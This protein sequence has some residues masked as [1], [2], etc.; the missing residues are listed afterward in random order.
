MKIKRIIFLYLL[1]G[2]LNGVLYTADRIDTSTFSPGAQSIGLGSSL[3]GGVN[4]PSAIYWNSAALAMVTA[5][6]LFLTVNAPYAINYCAL[7]QFIPNYGTFGVAFAAIPDGNITVQHTS[8]AWAKSFA[9]ALGLG[10]NFDFQQND[11]ALGI[12]GGIGLYYR[13]SAQPSNLQKI[14][15]F[16]DL[17]R[18]GTLSFG[19]TAVNLPLKSQVQKASFR[20]GGRYEMHDTGVLIQSGIHFQPSKN[21]FHLGLGGRFR[22]LVT[23]YVG[24][25]NFDTK[26]L[27]YGL[28]FNGHSYSVDGVYASSSRSVQLSL[29]IHLGKTGGEI[30]REYTQQGGKVLRGGDYRQALTWYDRALEYHLDQDS[31]RNLIRFLEKRKRKEDQVIDSLQILAHRELQQGKYINAAMLYTKV[32]RIDAR[33]KEARQ[34][35]KAIKPEI[36]IFIDRVYNT[37]INY[38]DQRDFKNAQQWFKAILVISEKHQGAQQYLEQI[39]DSLRLQSEIHFYRGWGFEEQ[40]DLSRAQ[41]EYETALNLDP[42]FEQNKQRYENLI[43]RIQKQKA[44]SERE[45]TNNLAKAQENYS[46]GKKVA[47]YQLYKKVLEM[48]AQNGEAQLGVQQTEADV[49]AYI[50]RNFDKGMQAYN[51]RD[52]AQAENIFKEVKS[53][54]NLN[55]TLKS[56]VQRATTYLNQINALKTAACDEMYQAGLG[57]LQQQKWEAALAQFEQMMRLKC[58]PEV[59][60]EKYQE[61]LSLMGVDSLFEQGKRFFQQGRYFEARQILQQVLARRPDYRKAFSYIEKSQ[62]QLNKTCDTHFNLGMNYY[63]EENYEAAIEEWNQVLRIN[64]EHQAAIEYI[65]RANERIQA[66]KRLR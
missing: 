37:A 8:V 63:A 6:Q 10:C 57:L 13:F 55:L 17:L 65:K 2:G 42:Y 50:V 19:A 51:K 25:Q 47:A 14:P 9:H 26:Y 28:Q 18:A 24:T 7:S 22:D 21:S 45:I 11:Q 3:V 35:L 53:I 60:F 62:T 48:D 29:N 1:L 12:T 59:A 54:G 36:D 43:A 61:T 41:Q 16:R 40:N 58:N 34:N 49:T 38:F 39:A 46:R 23:I 31:I 66:I 5:R 44:E 52:L 64:P 4:N 20:L 56:Y 33:S 32:L 27:A 15:W 30:A